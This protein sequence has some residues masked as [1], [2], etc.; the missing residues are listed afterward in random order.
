MAVI[1]AMMMTGL[2]MVTAVVVDLGYVRQS[3]VVDQN[4]ADLSALAASTQLAARRPQAACIDAANTLKTNMQGVG[5]LNTTTLC[6]P[7]P[8]VACNPIA[9]T[10]PASSS[11]TVNGF[12]VTVRYPVTDADIADPNYGAGLADGSSC[13][14]MRL[15]IASTE[16]AF[17]GA[18]ANKSSYKIS[19]SATVRATYVPGAQIPALWLLDPWGCTSLAVTG[20]AQL[21]AGTATSPG[22]IVADSDGSSCT[23]SQSTIS[24]TG[25]GTNLTAAP[26]SGPSRGTI[27][28]YSMGLNAT[29]CTMPSCDPADVAAARITPQPLH[30]D[31][32]ASRLPVDWAYN[33]KSGYPAYHSLPIMDCPYPKPAYVD[34]LKTAIGTSGS[35]PG[36]QKWSSSYS[37]NPSGTT[38]VNG[39]WWVDCNGGLKIGNGTHITFA[40]GNVVFD[41]PFDMTGGSLSFNTSNPSTALASSCVA[42]SVTTPCLSSSSSKAAIVYVRDGSIKI[43][44][45][46]LTARGVTGFLPNGYFAATGGAP[47]VWLGSTEGPLAGLA[48]WSDFASS[49]FQING[50]AGAQLEGTFFTP[51]AQ[52]FSLAGGSNWGQ[53]D[54]QFITYQLAVSGGGQISLNPR[55]NAVTLPQ[56]Y[57]R[58]IR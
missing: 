48:M 54:A 21:T 22:V 39:N 34:L 18:I 24:A 52:P 53:Q 43:T 28:L 33:C 46:A 4:A 14:R 36:F 15:S 37:C 9:P 42:P 23:G 2:L 31:A 27:K 1:S 17:F 47:P 13:E 35:P 55:A 44:G 30:L 19:R 8:V 11:Q 56:K 29:T 20:G 3:T 32:R 16:P 5:S 45:G 25:A 26:T 10:S 40:S 41:K 6:N 58:L 50:G 38:T 12:T 49:Q 57:A 7:M 51:E